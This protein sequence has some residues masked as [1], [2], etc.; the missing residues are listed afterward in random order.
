MLRVV[1]FVGCKNLKSVGT[2]WLKS[3]Y[4]FTADVDFRGLDSIETI[5]RG[6]MYPSR[7]N[8]PVRMLP[9]RLKIFHT[10]PPL[11]SDGFVFRARKKQTEENLRKW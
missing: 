11:V 10:S 9:E 8:P 1:S 4:M 2:D 3:N 6:W 5:G 7:R